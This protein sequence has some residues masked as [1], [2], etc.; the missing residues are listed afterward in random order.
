MAPDDPN[1]ETV[2]TDAPTPQAVEDMTEEAMVEELVSEHWINSY[3]GKKVETTHWAKED[4]QSLLTAARGIAKAVEAG[5]GDDVDSMSKGDVVKELEE[6]GAEFNKKEKRDDLRDVLREARLDLALSQLDRRLKEGGIEAAE[7]VDDRTSTVPATSTVNVHK[8][9]VQRE[10]DAPIPGT[11]PSKKDLAA[12]APELNVS[13]ESLKLATKGKK[14][15]A[16]CIEAAMNRLFNAAICGDL[17]KAT[18][19]GN[20]VHMSG[21]FRL[22]NGKRIPFKVDIREETPS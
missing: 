4:L 11:P 1:A 12:R 8:P 19:D 21:Q 15:L 9:A 17:E 10:P 5:K 13:A 18:K 16:K 2:V 22:P 3:N 14:R 20:V 6:K 7:A